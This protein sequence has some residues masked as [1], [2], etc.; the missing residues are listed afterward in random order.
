MFQQLCFA[1]FVI[2]AV[3][4]K[5]TGLTFDPE[6][7]RKTNRHKLLDPT[8][9]QSELPWHAKALLESAGVNM[10]AEVLLGPAYVT[11]KVRSNMY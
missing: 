8:P 3:E 4:A 6:H 7:R 9:T 5:P 11:Y 10:H 2:P 1:G